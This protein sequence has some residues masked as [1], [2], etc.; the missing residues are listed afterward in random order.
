M[1]FLEKFCTPLM[2]QNSVLKGRQ[3]HVRAPHN[4]AVAASPERTSQ[5]A[6]G[7]RCPQP[8]PAPPRPHLTGQR[9]RCCP[10]PRAE[11]RAP[12]PGCAVRPL[13][14]PAARQR[15]SLRGWRFPPRA[16]ALRPRVDYL[17]WH[18]NAT[19]PVAVAGRTGL[20]ATPVRR[21]RLLAAHLYRLPSSFKRPPP[22]AR[23]ETTRLL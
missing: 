17:G 9:P 13:P 4:R 5:A 11:L 16:A 20:L 6:W 8:T 3:R 19:S 14:Q 23:P 18:G 7:T 1:R 2:H 21:H 22:T 15:C 10:Q 12:G